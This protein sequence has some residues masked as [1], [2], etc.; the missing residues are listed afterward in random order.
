[1]KQDK[2]RLA[3]IIISELKDE[4][5]FKHL[6][7]NLI[8]TIKVIEDLDGIKIE[9][10]APIYDTIKYQEEG[11]IQYKNFSG[12][13]ASELDKYGSHFRIKTDKDGKEEKREI[14]PGN[15]KG[16]ID[17]ILNKALLRYAAETNQKIEK[18]EDLNGN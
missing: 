12:S 6:S 15:H 7:K 4:F 11:I 1:M 18:I 17:K 16:Y 9:I 2:Q 14:F 3:N 5:S 13:Y 8:N 10:P